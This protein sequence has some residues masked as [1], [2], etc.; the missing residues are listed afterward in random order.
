MA[1]DQLDGSIDGSVST[2]SSI[3]G[4]V[5]LGFSASGVVDIPGSYYTVYDGPYEITPT[6]DL[7]E[8]ETRSKL[9]R[10]DVTV[11]AIPYYETSNLS[12]GYTAIIGG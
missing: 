6:V 7:Q 8:L 9:M 12:G 2:E 1:L 5:E 4:T 11:L 10:D 3:T